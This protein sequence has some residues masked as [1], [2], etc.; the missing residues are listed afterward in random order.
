MTTDGLF[1][2]SNYTAMIPATNKK[3]CE[4]YL[5]NRGIS[6]AVK[7]CAYFDGLWFIIFD[8]C[9]QDVEVSFAGGIYECYADYPAKGFAWTPANFK[10]IKN[11]LSKS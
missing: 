3:N 8:N 4:R 1:K 11:N 9:P 5:G 10:A 2:T 7:R 6:E